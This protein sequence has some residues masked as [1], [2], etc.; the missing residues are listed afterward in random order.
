MSQL[1]RIARVVPCGKRHWLHSEPG[2]GLHQ[3][4][5][6]G[7]QTHAETP[8]ASPVPAFAAAGGWRAFHCCCSLGEGTVAGAQC[9]RVKLALNQAGD[10]KKGTGR[11]SPSGVVGAFGY[12]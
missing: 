9:G 12:G 10:A 1:A 11:C 5:H 4:M 2:T 7:S 8:A 3:R 6:W